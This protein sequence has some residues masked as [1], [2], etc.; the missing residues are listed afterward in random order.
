MFTLIFY[1]NFGKE[2]VDKF[3]YLVIKME[4]TDVRIKILDETSRLK[5]IASITFDDVFVIHEIR[6][7]EGREG[8]FIAMPSRK[9][10]DGTYKDIAHP[11]N[12]EIR[13]KIEKSI[14]KKYT[15]MIN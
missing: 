15:E 13:S 3:V 8:L 9:A 14:I 1:K 4:I 11:L 6:I 5:A 10:K 7:I 2:K 12:S